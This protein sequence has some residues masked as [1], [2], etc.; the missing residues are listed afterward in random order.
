M[1]EVAAVSASRR[2]GETR[3]CD[4]VARAWP[5]TTESMTPCSSEIA[6]VISAV[7]VVVAWKLATWKLEGVK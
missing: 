3:T 6:V 4:A 2:S 7:T 1:L 5:V